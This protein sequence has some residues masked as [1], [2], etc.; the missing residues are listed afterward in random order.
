MKKIRP[1]DGDLDI[2]I[3]SEISI[4]P[5]TPISS[6]FQTSSNVL[7]R[8]NLVEIEANIEILATD[9]NF[10]EKKGS[11][12]IDTLESYKLKRNLKIS[13]NPKNRFFNENVLIG[14]KLC[15]KKVL[16]FL[17]PHSTVFSFAILTNYSMHRRK[18]VCFIYESKQH[19]CDVFHKIF[20]AL[21]VLITFRLGHLFFGAELIYQNCPFKIRAIIVISILASFE[22][23][24]FFS[25]VFA[26]LYDDPYKV[27]VFS[28][29][30]SISSFFLVMFVIFINFL[31][32]PTPMKYFKNYLYFEF[33]LSLLP[34]I[35]ILL[36]KETFPEILE[37]MDYA[38]SSIFLIS[39]LNTVLG[40]I[41]NHLLLISVFCENTHLKKKEMMPGANIVAEFFNGYK[42]GTLMQLQETKMYFWLDLLL[43]FIQK[44]IRNAGFEK[45]AFSAFLRWKNPKRAKE[46]SSKFSIKRHFLS[47]NHLG[48]FFFL[49]FVFLVHHHYSYIFPSVVYDYEKMDYPILYNGHTFQELFSYTKTIIVSFFLIIVWAVSNY[50]NS[51]EKKK[52]FFQFFKSRNYKQVFRETIFNFKY[53]SMFNVGVELSLIVSGL[54]KIDM[55]GYFYRAFIEILNRIK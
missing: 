41:M 26:P 53:F 35:T 49:M 8:Q 47:E 38:E 9:S 20:V 21:Q 14:L 15:L 30:W 10:L 17:I 7:K 32:V 4:S 1:S 36:T 16:Y 5:E 34:G 22:I 25:L 45:R 55:N 39:L 28:I 13:T 50:L 23:L 11:P 43:F 40:M 31:K 24:I 3:Q 37:R 27:P 19:E 52:T 6:P 48:F 44:I 51:K 2:E 18:E 12:I 33:C 42:I 54:I 46:L 29:I